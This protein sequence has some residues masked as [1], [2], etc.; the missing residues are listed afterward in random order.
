MKMEQDKG[1]TLVTLVI[2]VIVLVIIAGITVYSGLDVIKRAN[3]ESM[4][5]N[6]L[7]IQAKAKEYVE[8]ADFK[9][10]PNN[11]ETKKVEV[12]NSYNFKKASEVTE[13]SLP[14]KFTGDNFYYVTTDALNQMGLTNIAEELKD[15]E[16]YLVEFNEE[17]LEVEVYNTLGYDGKY[18][19]TELEE[20]Q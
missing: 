16:A 17:D 5:T 14:D 10:G 3:L 8:E 12:Y 15:E 6:M 2:T 9:M 4:R 1:I 20:L 11:D 19:L 18:S 13:I 7:L